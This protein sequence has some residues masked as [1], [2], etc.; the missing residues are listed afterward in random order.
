MKNKQKI[1]FLGAAGTVTGSKYLLEI[2][3]KKILIDCGLFQGLKKLREL[4]WAYLPVNAHEIDAVLLTHGHLDHVGFL[5]RLVKMGYKGPI[6]S[7][8]PSLSIAKIILADSGKIQEEEAKHANEEGFSKHEPA[9]P[10]YNLEEAENT[11]Q[12]MQPLPQG[13]WIPLFDNIEVRFQFASHII[14]A[15]YIEINAEGKRYVF[16]GDIGRKN[17][18]LLEPPTKPQEAD[19]LLIETTYGDR[20][21][22]T[23]DAMEILADIIVKTVARGGSLFIPSFAVERSQ[24]IMYMLW[25]LKKNNLIPD[26]PMVMDSPMGDRVLEVFKN[27][28]DWHRKEFSEFKEMMDAFRIVKSYKETWEVVDSKASKIVIAGSGMVTGGRILTYLQY[29]LDKEETSVLLVGFQAEG[30]RGRALKEGQA[31]IKLRGKFIPV[32]AQIHS[33]ES[34]SSHADQTELLDWLSEI[35]EAPE[36]VFLVHGEN[37]ARDTFRMKLEN[38]KKWNVALPELFEV[39]EIE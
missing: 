22:P 27:N 26:V 2:G 24:T 14:G 6:Y 11:F 17:D 32:K 9:E 31:E 34:L 39:R 20:I 21:H 23:D 29:Y 33:I 8:E 4:N 35:K 37:E 19:I 13:E 3:T 10:L 1:H 18:L 12:Y 38:E 30:T 36:Q 16:S 25:Q 15:S 7:T 28:P 5:P